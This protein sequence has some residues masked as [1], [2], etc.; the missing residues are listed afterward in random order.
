M[1]LSQK[2]QKKVN[3]IQAFIKAFTF[4]QEQN[5]KYFELYINEK[6]KI[7]KKKYR[8]T[9]DEFEEAIRR[10]YERQIPI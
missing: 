7:K 9:A 10:L 4:L 5:S 3:K 1:A 6:D 2:L 8:K